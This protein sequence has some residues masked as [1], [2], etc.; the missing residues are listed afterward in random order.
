MVGV[1]TVGVITVG[2]GSSSSGKS[3]CVNGSVMSS[4]S[5]VDWGDVIDADDADWNRGDEEG[6]SAWLRKTSCKIGCCACCGV[7]TGEL[8]EDDSGGVA[9]PALFSSGV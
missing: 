8:R 5:Y 1:M 7:C 4:K 9:I 3:N 2:N 6:D